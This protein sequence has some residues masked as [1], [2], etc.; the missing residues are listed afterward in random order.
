MKQEEIEIYEV[1][2]D[3]EA[4]S[5]IERLV[6][7]KKFFSLPLQVKEVILNCQ[8]GK[9][10]GD[11][12][13]TYEKPTRIE[14]YKLRLPNPDTKVGKSNGYRLIY[15]IAIERKLVNILTVYY[16]KEIPNLPDVA[17]RSLVNSFLRKYVLDELNSYEQE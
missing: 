14:V 7:K 9:F 1:I 16:K 2:T 10:D 6:R 5:N 12:V 3:E 11:N 8:Q 15:A 17:I 13:L 4:E